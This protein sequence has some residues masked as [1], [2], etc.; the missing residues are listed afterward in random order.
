MLPIWYSTLLG[1]AM[2]VQHGDA[3][4]T[5]VRAP[6]QWTRGVPIGLGL[7]LIGLAGFELMLSCLQA[8]KSPDDSARLYSRKTIAA[9]VETARLDDSGGPAPPHESKFYASQCKI[10]SEL[11]A[12]V[13]GYPNVSSSYANCLLRTGKHDRAGEVLH[14]ALSDRGN[15][16]D[17]AANLLYESTLAFPVEKLRCVQRSLRAGELDGRLRE[18]LLRISQFPA[19]QTTL[20]AELPAARLLA[21]Q[22]SAAEFASATIELLRINAFIK[23]R[24]GETA[25]AI[26]DQRLAAECYQ[27]LERTSNL[28]RRRAEAEVEAFY[29]LAQM[30]YQHDRVNYRQAFDAIREAERYAV[31]GIG[32]EW[33]ADRQPERGFVIGEVMPTEFPERLRPM[34]RLSALLGIVQG[35]DRDL[36]FRVYFSLPPHRWAPVDLSAEMA[37]VARAAYD[38]LG[39]IPENKRPAHYQFLPDTIRRYD[40]TAADQSAPPTK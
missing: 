3:A 20:V 30:I 24:S 16:F 34:W 22:K 17:P 38:D 6:L 13:P 26:S 27:R 21:A 5:D 31:L 11:N 18:I 14:E 28:Y 10:W 4:T 36:H 39:K 29:T 32:H 35:D 37:P 8:I 2:A 7:V 9:R 19:V 23:S 1:L 33:V 25:E 40:A 12:L 15:Q